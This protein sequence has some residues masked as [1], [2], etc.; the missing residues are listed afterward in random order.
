ML[1]QNTVSF[2][3]QSKQVSR[4]CIKFSTELTCQI[5]TNQNIKIARR[6]WPTRDHYE[7]NQSDCTFLPVTA[8]WIFASEVPPRSV[9]NQN[10]N[11]AA[12]KHNL[13]HMNFFKK[14]KLEPAIIWKLVTCQR[15]TS[16]ILDLD[17]SIPEPAIRS[18]DTG[19]RTPCFDSCQV[20]TTLM[21]KMRKYE[22]N[23]KLLLGS[24]TS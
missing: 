22:C 3:C 7:K 16:K 4:C 2:S 13:F 9:W 18:G 19:Q 20:I 1:T 11:S 17:G 21:C 23:I 6:A 8:G 15:I 10:I 14:I 24:Q 12:H 5:L